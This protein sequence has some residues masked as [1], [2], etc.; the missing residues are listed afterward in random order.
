MRL[1]ENTKAMKKAFLIVGALIAGSI[2]LPF[3]HLRQTK[4]GPPGRGSPGDDMFR[5]RA[6]NSDYSFW[7]RIGVATRGLIAAEPHAV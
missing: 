4:P 1:A 7:Q 2:Y 3:L 5:R 6:E